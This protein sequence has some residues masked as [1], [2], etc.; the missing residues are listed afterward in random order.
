MIV[1]DITDIIEEYAPLSFQEDYDNSGLI[2]GNHNDEVRGVLISLDCI[3]SVL[4]EAIALNCDMIVSHHPIVFSGIKKFN[5]NN[6]IENVVIKAIK[7]NI[8]IYAA[9]TNLDNTP[10]GVSFKMAQKIGLSNCKVLQPKK[11]YLSKIVT[12][13][14]KDNAEEVR[15]AMFDAGAGNIGNYAECSFNS[16]GTG[17]YKGMAG[18]NPYLGTIGEP[19]QEEEIKIETIIP[20][21]LVNG[22]VNNLI[23]AHPYEEVAYDVYQLKNLHKNVGSGVIGELQEGEDEFDFLNRLKKDINTDCIRYTNP[24]GKKVKKVALCG[25]SGSFLLEDAIRAKAD[26]F[27]TGDF[28][29]HQF[30]DAEDKIMIADVGHY[31]SEQYTSELIYEILNKK[32]PNFAIRL[33]KENTNPV[34]YL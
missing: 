21:Y 12:Y 15:Q 4:E 27:I 33:S 34:N 23:K 11:D 13:C 19:H 16:I 25:G 3:D 30:F 22:V 29:Y 20:N 1:R 24:L 28:K 7:N 18:T 26:I 31:E 10:D 2:V 14:P 8:A 6:Y 17:T 5:G 9:H 32:I